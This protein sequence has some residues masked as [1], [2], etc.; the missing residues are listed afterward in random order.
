MRFQR[1]SCLTVPE[2]RPT[3][4][5][6]HCGVRGSIRRKYSFPL[7]AKV[8]ADIVAAGGKVGMGGHGQR[9]GIQCH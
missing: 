8:L 6:T 3:S 1:G 7:A 5:A 4:T 9:Q 2:G